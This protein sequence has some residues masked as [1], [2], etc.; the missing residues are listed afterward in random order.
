MIFEVAFLDVGHGDCAVVTFSSPTSPD[1]Q[2]DR[3]RCIVIDGGDEGARGVRF[4]QR[5]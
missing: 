1:G 5:R 4:L 2:H 3:T